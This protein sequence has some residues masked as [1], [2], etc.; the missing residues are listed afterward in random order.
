M[1]AVLH[2][3]MLLLLQAASAT[4]RSAA[5]GT[6]PPA[7]RAIHV[8]RT[9]PS[10]RAQ[11]LSWCWTQR[12]PPDP[13]HHREGE[14]AVLSWLKQTDMSKRSQPPECRRTLLVSFIL[15]HDLTVFFH[16][17]HR[18]YTSSTGQSVG[19]KSGFSCSTVIK[20]TSNKYARLTCKS[21]STTHM[22]LYT[23]RATRVL[24][25]LFA[26]CFIG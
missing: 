25:T 12:R 14:A 15:R 1:R 22:H 9:T 7:P 11:S 3:W 6:R 4:C 19:Y 23:N 21:S 16:Y 13:T 8:C 20:R 18:L 2:C 26:G 17:Y 5:A 10:L 24:Q